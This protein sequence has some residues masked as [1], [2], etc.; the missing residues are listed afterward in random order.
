MIP[1]LLRVWFAI[2]ELRDLR[3]AHLAPV[4]PGTRRL[5]GSEFRVGFRLWFN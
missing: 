4:G 1:L 3:P 2:V 5:I